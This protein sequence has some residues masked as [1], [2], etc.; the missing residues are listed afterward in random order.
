MNR[1]K[2]LSD[3]KKEREKI[4]TMRDRKKL[5]WKQIAEILGVSV[6]A[7]RRRYLKEKNNG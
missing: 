6:T 7:A 4:V 1:K 2:Y 5:E 3:L